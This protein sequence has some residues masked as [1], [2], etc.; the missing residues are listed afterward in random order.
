MPQPSLITPSFPAGRQPWSYHNPVKIVF[1]AGQFDRLGTLAAGQSLLLVTTPGFRCRGM[2]DRVRSLL[3]DRLQAVFDTVTPNPC[4]HALVRESAPFRGHRFDAVVAVGGGSVMDTAKFLRVALAGEG[5]AGKVAEQLLAGKAL[6]D[7]AM[8]PLLAVPTTS[9]TGSE[10]TP[11]ATIWDSQTHK[12]HSLMSRRLFPD[13]ALLDPALTVD[14]PAEPTASSGLD[15]LSQA[16][17]SV[18]NRNWDAVSASHSARA[19][20]LALSHLPT[21]MTNPRDLVARSALMEASLLA[22]LAISQ[23]RTALA[24]SM[25]YPITARLGLPHGLACSFMLPA[26]LEFN[27]VADEGTI[28]GLVQAVGLP[29]WKALQSRIEELLATCRMND[30]LARY[31]ITAA[32]T[33]PLAAEMFTPGRVDNNL[34]PPTEEDVRSLLVKSLNTAG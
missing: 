22:G 13:V 1:G 4:V 28:S 8:L 7:P 21:L 27:A 16:L 11:F 2:V 14:L 29:D 31:G 19:V 15:A 25:S 26:L 23:T 18:W 33:L 5:D 10:V 20:A 6:G 32:A 3:G 34:R 17:E 12:K 9:G 24:H 30:W